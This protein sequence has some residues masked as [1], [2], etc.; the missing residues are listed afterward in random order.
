MQQNVVYLVKHAPA[1]FS[2]VLLVL[3]GEFKKFMVDLSQM[4]A[5]V[6]HKPT[7]VLYFRLTVEEAMRRIKQRAEEEGRKFEEGIDEKY[8]QEL[9]S[10]YEELY[11]D[12]EDV[13][14]LD[15]NM[16]PDE[17]KREVADQLKNN[18]AKYHRVLE[19]K[20]LSKEEAEELLMYMISCF[21]NRIE[22]ALHAEGDQNANTRPE[23]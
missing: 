3:Q 18:I 10:M 14:R 19:D 13:I 15:S 12:R 20:G 11:K 21:V 5:D 2:P 6:A 23:D 22:P 17:I 4:N 1:K 16:P 9:D 8:L 7:L